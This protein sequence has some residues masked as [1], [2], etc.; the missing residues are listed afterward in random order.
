V[1]FAEGRTKL[2]HPLAGKFREQALACLSSLYARLHGPDADYEGQVTREDVRDLFLQA[3]RK[4]PVLTG[5]ETPASEEHDAKDETAHVNWLVRV[6]TE[7]GWIEKVH[8]KG[9]METTFRFSRVGKLLVERVVEI[10]N[11]GLR[12]RQ[13]NVRSTLHALN[14]FAAGG[15]PYDLIDALDTAKRVI[16]DLS[17]EVADLHERRRALMQEVSRMAANAVLDDL[18][19]YF[20]QRFRPDHAIRLQADSV[21]R[22][23]DRIRDVCNEIRNWPAERLARTDKHLRQIAPQLSGRD[24][25][26]LIRLVDQVEQ[27]VDAACTSKMPE[28]RA[29]LNAYMNRSNTLLRHAI[30]L[31]VLGHRT[32]ATLLKRFGNM[33]RAEQDG[34]L[35]RVG[36]RLTPFSPALPDPDRIRLRERLS[37][38]QLVESTPQAVPTVEERLEALLQQ[39]E[40]EAF[41]VTIDQVREII[42]TQTAEN[43]R[44]TTAGL[45]VTDV[46]SLLALS[47]AIEA[48]SI[49]GEG[50]SVHIRVSE[51]G[52]PGE[53]YENGYLKGH[54][55]VLEKVYAPS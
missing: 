17:D 32:L 41:S 39:A 43:D 34:L 19:D 44:M 15:D 4:T 55:F 42:L 29:A 24:G 9:V 50:E 28:F 38:R 53:R 7:S 11:P 2:F 37:H 51:G 26:A 31:S 21:E 54:L 6:L 14:S 18:L 47:H 5:D 35:A 22:H 13:R 16:S 8:D 10:A 49:G 40:D 45:A 1:F 48:G 3:I 36:E 27:Y 33:N 25:I 20:E 30:A 46:P 23:R 12:S 52:R